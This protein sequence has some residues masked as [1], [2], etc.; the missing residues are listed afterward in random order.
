MIFLACENSF[1]YGRSLTNNRKKKRKDISTFAFGIW[2]LVKK[3]LVENWPN[4]SHWQSAQKIKFHKTFLWEQ[5][6]QKIFSFFAQL[7]LKRV[8]CYTDSM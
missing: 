8:V 1:Y 2:Q 7:M 6:F 4:E 5:M 3:M